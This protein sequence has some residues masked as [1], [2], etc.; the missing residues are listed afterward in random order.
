[1]LRENRKIEK[2]V[3]GYATN[4]KVQQ[5]I[6]GDTTVDK[7]LKR[8]INEYIEKTKLTK[9]LNKLKIDK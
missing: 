4:G 8:R 5:D 2:F 9:K 1:M 6:L 7:S 3:D